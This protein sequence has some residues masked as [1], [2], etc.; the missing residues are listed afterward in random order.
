MKIQV[1]GTAAAEC[2][3]GIFCNDEFCRKI[4][5]VKGKNIRSRAQLIV[6]DVHVIDFGYDNFY[7]SVKFDIDFSKIRDIFIT[8]SHD[9]HY[10][11]HELKYASQ[12]RCAYNTEHTPITLYGNETVIN[13]ALPYIKNGGVAVCTLHSFKPITTKDGYIF[14]PI[15]AEHDD[16][17]E[18]MLNYIFEHDG[19]RVLYISDSGLYR[20]EETWD[21]ISQYKYDCVISECTLTLADWEPIGHQTYKGVLRL[22]E[23]LLGFGSIK[24][25]TPFYITHITHFLHNMLHEEWVEYASKDNI[26]VC[27]DGIEINI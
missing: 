6:D 4:R 11:P 27:Y 22:K 20:R 26:Q 12:G 1:L 10:F 7:H 19:K 15:L 21:Y 8:H 17:G 13:M 9:D 18:E 25:D 24:E 5:K 2:W 14:T 23:K 3:P 16:E